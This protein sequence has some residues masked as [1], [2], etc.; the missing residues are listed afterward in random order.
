[1]NSYETLAGT[2]IL[3][4]S[5]FNV[6][7]VNA[8][9]TATN[10]VLAFSRPSTNLSGSSAIILDSQATITQQG[11]AT[12][13]STIDGIQFVLRNVSAGALA[14]AGTAGTANSDGITWNYNATTGRLSMTGTASIAAY[15]SLLRTVAYTPTGGNQTTTQAIDINLGR[16]VYRFENGHYYEFVSFT[17]LGIDPNNTSTNGTDPTVPSWNTAKTLAAGRTLLGLQGYLATITSAA[18]DSFVQQRLQ[19]QG[20]IGASDAA[21]EGEWRWVTGPEG[22]ENSGAGRQFWQGNGSGSVTGPNNYANWNSGEPNNFVLSVTDEDYGH[23]LATG[24]W[25]DY[26]NTPRSR[27]SDQKVDGFVVEYGG[28]ANDPNLVSTRVTFTLGVPTV[29]TPDFLF[30]DAPSGST[31]VI[32]LNE[33]QV[34]TGERTRL[35]G[36]TGNTGVIAPDASWK[37]VGTADLNGDNRRDIVWHNTTSSETY[38]WFMGGALGNEIQATAPIVLGNST[39]ALRPQGWTPI[40]FADLLGSSLPEILWVNQAQ[41]VMGIWELN[42]PQTG[43]I[44]STI[45]LTSST[46]QQQGASAPFILGSGWQPYYGNFDGNA[47]TKELFW[48][49][50]LTGAVGYWTLNGS[51][52]TAKAIDGVVGFQQNI[53]SYKPVQVGDIDRDG[54]DD[55]VFQSGQFVAA[56]KMNGS[57]IAGLPTLLKNNDLGS[58]LNLV[59]G[60][61]DIDLDG[62]KDLLI[63]APASAALGVQGKYY[64]VIFLDSQTFSQR[65]TDGFRLIKSGASIYDAGRPTI[66][67]EATVDFD[68]LNNGIPKPGY[69]SNS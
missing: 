3:G 30:R 62:T 21:V 38:V 58:P 1:M 50:S 40:L 2:T 17:D 44:P 46:V 6:V 56:W 69:F 36:T 66:N 61:V 18:E 47:A 14:A 11:D 53:G 13:S 8:R 20:W 55:I 34:T 60:L 5:P 65:I 59:K 29:P 48:H 35:A 15:Q 64:S 22:L 52:F 32:N 42:V 27:S 31:V 41:G 9:S 63:E 37:I 23:Y 45:Q 49:N 24:K 10:P 25:N 43:A 39:T 67:L 57:T 51:V 16:P 26:E 28:F 4:E 7:S 19:G 68:L 12:G 54:K 33:N